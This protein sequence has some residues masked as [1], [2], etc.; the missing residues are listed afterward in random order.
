MIS[1][2][3][4][5]FLHLFYLIV[6]VFFVNTLAYVNKLDDAKINWCSQHFNPDGVEI[7]DNIFISCCYEALSTL[8]VVGYK[9]TN[10]TIEST[11][12]KLQTTDEALTKAWNDFYNVWNPVKIVKDQFNTDDKLIEIVQNDLQIVKSYNATAR[13]TLRIAFDRFDKA[14]QDMLTAGNN[15]MTV[16][17][18]F[19]TAQHDILTD[20]FD[21]TKKD[22]FIENAEKI[23]TATS[24]QTNDSNSLKSA[25]DNFMS[26]RNGLINAWADYKYDDILFDNVEKLV[27]DYTYNARNYTYNTRNLNSLKSA[28]DNVT[29]ANDNFMSARKG[30]IRACQNKYHDDSIKI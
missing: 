10:D 4:N 3:T 8:I 11:K 20:G 25:N 13:N 24:N 21:L 29:I 1:S 30:L 7:R 2:P 26:A 16:W 19:H 6:V 22:I 9:P 5:R 18:N 28:K 17:A 15:F 12:N 27:K 23:V 14:R